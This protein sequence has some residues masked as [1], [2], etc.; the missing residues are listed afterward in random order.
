[1]SLRTLAL[2]LVLPLLCVGPA[3]IPGKRFLPQLPCGFE[4]LASEAPERAAQAWRAANHLA[5]DRLFPALT[6]EMHVRES[7][8]RG[9]LPSWDPLSGMGMPLAGATMI[10]VWYPPNALKILLPPDIAGGWLALLTLYIA[11]LGLFVFLERRAFSWAACVCGALAMQAGAFGFANL[12]LSMK[13]GAA[14]WLP[15][16]LWAIE[17]LAQRRQ[18][19]G[20]VLFASTA[21]ALL[22]GFPPIAIFCIASAVAY[23]L[24][25]WIEERRAEWASVFAHSLGWIALGI[26]ASLVQILPMLEASLGSTRREE[27]VTRFEAQSLPSA[28][29]GT[30]VLPDLIGSPQDPV[31]ATRNALAWWLT[32]ADEREKALSANPLEWNQFA[33]IAVLALACAALAS[34]FKR[35]RIPAVL[36]L[37]V[38]GFVHGWPLVRTLYT[39]PG[40]DLGAPARVN[41]VAWMLWPW[42]A[43]IGLEALIAKKARARGAAIL[44][45]IACAAIGLLA[46]AGIDPATWAGTLPALLAKQQGVTVERVA[47]YVSSET[48]L[49]A[50]QRLVHSG[51]V[52]LVLS[53]AA[54]GAASCA[55]CL[56]GANARRWMVALWLALIA[57]DGLGLAREHLAP[58]DLAGQ[59]LFPSSPAIEAVRAAAGDG[60]VVRYDASDSGMDDVEH[61]ARPDLLSAYGIADLTPYTVFTPRSLVE[62]IT[63]IDPRSA[64][65]TGIGRISQASLFNHPVLDI[66][67]VTCVLSRSELVNPRLELVYSKNDFFVYHRSGALPIARVV[68]VRMIDVSDDDTL[69]GL[70]S[71]GGLDPKKVAVSVGSSTLAE[72]VRVPHPF[73]PGELTVHRPAPDRVDVHVANSSGGF[74]VFQEAYDAGWKAAVDGEDADVIRVDHVCRA[75]RIPA[76]SCSVR[77]KYEP[78]SLRLGAWCSLLAI[79]TALFCAWRGR[80]GKD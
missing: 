33:G 61:L 27:S 66:A 21:F 29:L 37:V 45:S 20:L 51:G 49:L 63:R 58:R 72:S 70:W 41:A 15:W 4:P 54:L 56:S 44:A 65:R 3:L 68:P 71:A 77:T 25:R 31:F 5:S 79:A 11:G 50:A 48:A 76:G 52:L 69:L 60:R 10:G 67:R 26:A 80:A 24:M 8:L 78:F 59:A 28:A 74:L 9:E 35:A 40:F 36:L 18:W 57:I 23:L 30:L 12:H 17:G 42:L 2:L 55:C 62:W 19:S 75:V 43:A 73:V 38:L 13:V 53:L 39:L 7:V 64:C 6:D 22:A 34:D 32:R 1:M 14:V 46:Y 16:S 47:E